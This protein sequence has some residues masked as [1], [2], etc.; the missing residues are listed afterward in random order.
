[1]EHTSTIHTLAQ[2][3]LRMDKVRLLP[4]MSYAYVNVEKDP[5]TRSEI[6]SL[7]DEGQTSELE[8]ILGTRK[9]GLH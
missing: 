8:K 1:M 2:E 9:Y 3:W 7:L 4:Q 6:E 5:I